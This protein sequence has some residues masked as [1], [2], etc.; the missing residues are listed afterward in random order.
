MFRKAVEKYG[1]A[2]TWYVFKKCFKIGKTNIKL[3][4]LE[5]NRQEKF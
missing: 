5:N 4:V 2:E 1:L 3:I